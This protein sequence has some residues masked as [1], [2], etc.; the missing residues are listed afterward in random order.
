MFRVQKPLVI[1]L[2]MLVASTAHLLLLRT[3]HTVASPSMDVSLP[4]RN[5]HPAALCSRPFISTFSCSL[6]KAV[7]SLSSNVPACSSITVPFRTCHAIHAWIG[8][9]TQGHKITEKASMH[10]QG[11]LQASWLC[12][13]AHLFDQTRARL[14]PDR[15]ALR[16]C[17][18][19]AP[20]LLRKLFGFQFLQRQPL[21]PAYSMQGI[22]REGQVLSSHSL[23][24][25]L[26]GC[27]ALTLP[28]RPIGIR[29]LSLRKK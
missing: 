3:T 21:I 27:R 13:T 17:C 20:G 29:A 9:A 24:L 10:V 12:A 5:R 28:C 1:V 18:F 26:E 16:A 19:I 15:D 8:T 22:Q 7:Q 14:I 6:A 2:T 25:S 4:S 23:T 11:E